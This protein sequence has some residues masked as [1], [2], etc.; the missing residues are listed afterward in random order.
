MFSSLGQGISGAQIYN[1]APLEQRAWRFQE[2]ILSPRV[3]RF[4][5]NQISW[6][7]HEYEASEIEPQPLSR[8]DRFSAMQR[9]LMTTVFEGNKFQQCQHKPNEE[10]D[11]HARATSVFYNLVRFY[12]LLKL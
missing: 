12:S 3:L 1:M 4:G 2:M 7:C 6:A 9:L 8:L 11:A 10:C 5:Q